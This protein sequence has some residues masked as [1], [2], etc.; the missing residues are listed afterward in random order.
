MVNNMVNNMVNYD[1]ILSEVKEL[2]KKYDNFNSKNNKNIYKNHDEF[3]SA[4][5][6]KY[7]NMATNQTKIF[8]QCVSGQMN[9]E[10]FTYMIKQAKKVQ[11]HKI[12]SH[13]ASIKVG[14]ELVEKFIKPKLKNNK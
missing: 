7:Q 5:T 10:I 3:V 4:M 9:I 11:Q 2:V 1:I 6:T 12:S 8:E 13:N 14:E